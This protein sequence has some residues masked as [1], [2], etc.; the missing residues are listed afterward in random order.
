MCMFSSL[1][2]W[3]NEDYSFCSTMPIQLASKIK[4]E[5]LSTHCKYFVLFA[6]PLAWVLANFYTHTL[7]NI[8]QSF[9]N[10]WWRDQQE[11]FHTLP[12]L[13][14]WQTDQKE[15]F[16]ALL[17]HNF[18]TTY[19]IHVVLYNNY[20][21]SPDVNIYICP[22]MRITVS[23]ACKIHNITMPIFKHGHYIKNHDE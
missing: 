23:Y 16:D 7:C 8:T 4:A 2:I 19:I 21:K 14:W 5:L 22:W 1:L 3:V 18:S 9:F 13:Y 10:R 17:C 11:Y 6:N 20:I 15:Y 12:L